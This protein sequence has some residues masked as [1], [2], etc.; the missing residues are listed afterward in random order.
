[1]SLLDRLKLE[2]LKEMTNIEELFNN[3]DSNKPGNAIRTQEL[4]SSISTQ[5]S[6]P[7]RGS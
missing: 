3:I 5:L 2:L 6:E 1:M 7:F 4:G